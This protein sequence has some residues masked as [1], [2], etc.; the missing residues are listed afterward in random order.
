MIWAALKYLDLHAGNGAGG[1]VKL[2]QLKQIKHDLE[3]E[4]GWPRNCSWLSY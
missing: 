4:I 3:D 1:P 2:N